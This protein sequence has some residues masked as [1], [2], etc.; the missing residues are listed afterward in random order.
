MDLT[1]LRTRTGRMLLLLLAVMVPLTPLL[2]W[3]EGQGGQALLLGTGI[4]LAALVVALMAA[5]GGVASPAVGQAIAVGIMAVVSVHVAL[6][7]AGW[8]LDVH[9]AYFAAL[10]LLAGF[11]DPRPILLGT[12]T[13]A[14]HHVAL[15]FAAP[16]LVFGTPDGDLGRVVLHAVILLVEAAGLLV[17]VAGMRRAAEAARA[18][19]VQ[20]EHSRQAELAAVERRQ[21]LEAAAAREA[22][23]ARA[24]TA[25]R[26]ERSLGGVAQGV[27]AAS[28]TLDDSA[29]RIAAEAEGAARE[30]AIAQGAVEEASSGVQTVAA[31]SEQ[32][33]AAV[34]EITRQV[35]Q[36]SQVA[37]RAS[38]QVE[39]TDALVRSLSDGAQRIGDVV[40]LISDI[41]GQTNLLAL[42]ATIE[43]A[44][45]GDAGKG[46]AVVASEVKNLA[47]QTA[48][49]TEEIGHQVG[50]IQAAT[51]EAVTAM[52]SIA[53][54]VGEVNEVAAIIAAAVAEQGNATREIAGASAEVARGTGNASAAVTRAVERIGTTA[55]A[56]TG[57]ERMA[58]GL[59]GEAASLRAAVGETAQGLRAA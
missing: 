53:G 20:A 55:E 24:A 15:N 49:A 28:G 27:E 9:M 10:A 22:R 37:G 29:K 14:L 59:R 21:A 11:C 1:D 16:A 23:E 44:R 17:L 32:L 2:G 34:A 50:A 47:G 6:A 46:F 54:V 41:A 57:L 43:A 12:L 30:A 18:A 38:A 35:A 56:V 31:A 39:G 58:E 51:A 8:R 45:A 25:E 13:V 3:L 5:R 52:Q 26:I 42:N 4:A 33:A 40:R 48:K 19:I 7:P 36:A